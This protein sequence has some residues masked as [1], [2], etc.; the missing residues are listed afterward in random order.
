MSM[1]GGKIFAENDSLTLSDFGYGRLDVLKETGALVIDESP[2]ASLFDVTEFAIAKQRKDQPLLNKDEA[3]AKAAEANVSLEIPDD[4]ITSAALDILIG[5]QQEARHRNHVF[6]NRDDDPGAWS[7]LQQFGVGLAASMV[8]PLNIATALVP[9]FAVARFASAAKAAQAEKAFGPVQATTAARIG[10]A[11]LAAPIRTA[12]AE[13]LVGAAAVEAIVLPSQQYLQSD[14]DMYDSLLNL[15]LGTAFASGVQGIARGARSISEARAIRSAKIRADIEK[16]IQPGVDATRQAG[17]EALT[18][19]E[20]VAEKML[21]ANPE[22]REAIF[23][24]LVVRAIENRDV[25]IEA[26]L[27]ADIDALAG[28]QVFE[29]DELEA[30]LDADLDSALDEISKILSEEVLGKRKT[31]RNV[32]QIAELREAIAELYDKSAWVDYNNGAR[33][34]L[35]SREAKPAISRLSEAEGR[36]RADRVMNAIDA[37]EPRIKGGRI[38]GPV[39]AGM[40]RLRQLAER[41]QAIKDMV[42]RSADE[43]QD[44]INKHPESIKRLEAVREQQIKGDSIHSDPAVSRLAD[45]AISTPRA[46]EDDLKAQGDEY[47]VD[48]ELLSAGIQ[49]RYPDA[50]M[51]ELQAEISEADKRSR[52]TAQLVEDSAACVAA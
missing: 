5:R 46:A 33:K 10:E 11:A 38:D 20:R 3:T 29:L 40:G 15:G 24:A 45:E 41:R 14:Y 23:Q 48:T 12:A 36:K 34:R 13:A 44:A 6:A 22:T 16:Q 37:L 4:G 42:V 47:D 18:P 19:N 28:R 26:I 52:R 27:D 25:D 1:Y 7:M 43:L 17:R 50:D 49:A 39:R 9:N 30:T 35:K 32:K 51:T 21:A 31:A 8:D 2:T